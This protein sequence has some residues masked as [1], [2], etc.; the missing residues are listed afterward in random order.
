MSLVS[1][2]DTDTV[3][4]LSY[5]SGA[6]TNIGGDVSYVG[7]AYTFDTK[8]ATNQLW[9]FGNGAYG[10]LGQ[11]NTVSYSSPVQLP[12]N[13]VWEKVYW[14]N[15]QN[16]FILAIKSDNTL[17][18]WGNNEDGVIGNN[19]NTHYSSPV[20]I[21]GTWGDVGMMNSSYSYGNIGWKYG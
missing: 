7:T 10:M 16:E 6:F 2:L 14:G 12:G 4:H 18:S 13:P 20:Q 11:N 8:P 19:S 17:W 1:E 21:P 15:N 9:G 5:P 3:Y